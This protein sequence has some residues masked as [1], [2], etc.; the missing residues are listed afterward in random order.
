[1][2]PVLTSFRAVTT[3]GR[4]LA[5]ALGAQS[6]WRWDGTQWAP[7]ALP[8]DSQLPELRALFADSRDE[9]YVAGD[10]GCSSTARAL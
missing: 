1:M 4:D 5:W 7:V 6:L 3:L 2:L 10:G 9:L 8:A